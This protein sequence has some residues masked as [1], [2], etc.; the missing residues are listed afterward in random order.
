MEIPRIEENPSIVIRDRVKS[1]M[2]KVLDISRT[3]A[4]SD[5]DFKSTKSIVVD[6]AYNEIDR[7]FDSLEKAGIL[8]SCKCKS[9]TSN[10]AK[11]FYDPNCDCNGTG[12]LSVR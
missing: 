1:F 3:K 11:A 5:A 9:G 7:I 12:Y 8:R 10:R 4:K 6:L 2:K